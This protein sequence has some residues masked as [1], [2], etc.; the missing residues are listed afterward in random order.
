MFS[1]TVLGAI[2]DYNHLEVRIALRENAVER[3]TK[4]PQSVVCGDNDRDE[5]LVGHESFFRVFLLS[6]VS[7]IVLFSSSETVKLYRSA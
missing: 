5:W 1:S 6:I 2:I 7:H 3:S 4:L